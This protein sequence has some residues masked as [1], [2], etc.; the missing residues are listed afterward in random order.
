VARN[1][2]TGKLDASPV[3]VG[4]QLFLRS[5]STLYGFSSAEQ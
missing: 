2:L 5:W 3:A 4:S 1:Q